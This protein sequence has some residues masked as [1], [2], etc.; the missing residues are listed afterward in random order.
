[1][2][3]VKVGVVGCGTISGVYFQAGQRFPAFDIV[4]CADILSDKAEARATEFG[5]PKA[6]SVEE[7]LADPDI[8]LVINL[9]IPAAHAEVGVAALEAGKSVYNEKPLAV[10]REDGLRMLELAKRKGVRIGGAPDTFMGGGIQTCRKLVDD[11]WIGAPVAATAFLLGHGHES[12]HPNPDF[13]Y[14]PGGGPMFDMG[15]Y[16]LTALTVLMG[17]VRRVTGA[18]RITFPERTITS[19]P[20]YGEKIQVNVPTHVAGLLDFASGAIGTVITSFDVWAHGLPRIEIYGT[21]GSLSVPDPNGFGGEVRIRRAGASE[22]SVM[23]LSH[24]YIEQSRGVGVADMAYALGSG[25]PHRANGELAYHVL[26]IMHAIHDAS[27]D[28]K[29]VELSS[30]TDRPAPLPLGLLPYTLDP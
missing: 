3:P 23:P 9:T 14:Q 22:W 18:T 20:K 13:Y 29:H 17:A 21:E 25:R 19:Q 26:D 12:W 2:K 24:G 28:G 15:P 27:R 1:M 6:C 4:A 16:Y 30:H 8:E 7:L 10:T 11:G 5:I